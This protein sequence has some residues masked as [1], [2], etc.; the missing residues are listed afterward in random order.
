MGKKEY[1]NQPCTRL[2]T[3]IFSF[4]FINPFSIV[5]VL[6]GFGYN[7]RF[8]RGIIKKKKNKGKGN[9]FHV[10]RAEGSSTTGTSWACVVLPHCR[11]SSWIIHSYPKDGINVIQEGALSGGCHGME[12][13]AFQPFHTW[14]ELRYFSSEIPSTWLGTRVDG[15][16]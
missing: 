4:V 13:A 10:C 2:K 6:R 9:V 3:Q 15:R 12:K 14:E 7:Y 1:G 11:S 5:S 16:I 8:G